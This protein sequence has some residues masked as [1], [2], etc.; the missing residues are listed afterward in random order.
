MKGVGFNEYCVVSPPPA[1]VYSPPKKDLSWMGLSEFV[2]DTVTDYT[3]PTPSLDV[4]KSVSKF[5]AKGDEGSFLGNSLSSKAFR[6][7]NK[8]TKKIEENLHV[9]FL[10]NKSI[11]KGTSP[12]WL[13]DIDTLT[14]SMNYVPVVIEGTSST[15]I[16][17]IKEDVHQAAAKKDAAILDNN[18]SQKEQQEANGDK[19]VPESS[20]NSNPTASTK[21]FANDSFE[22]ASSSTVFPLLVHMFQL[23]A[24][25]FLRLE[26]FFGDTYNA[27]SLNEVESDLSNMETTIQ[28]SL[29]PTLRIH[30]DH[31]KSQIIGPVD[32]PFKIQNVWVLVDYPSGVRPIETKWVLK[33]KKDERGIVIRN[34]A[35]LVAQGHTREEVS[36]YQE[37]FAPVARIEAIRLFLAYASYM[38]FTVYQMDV[39]SAFLYGTINEE[40]YV[41][42][43]LAFKI[44]SSYTEFTRGT[45]DQTLLVRKHKGEF[46]LVQVS[47]IRSLMYLTASRPDIMFAVCACARYQV[48][49]KE[50]H[51]YAVKRIFRYLKGNPKLGLWYPKESPFDLVAYSD[52]DYGG[53]NQ[54]RKSTTGGC[55]FLGRSL[56]RQHSLMEERIQSQDLEITQLKTRVKTLKDNEKRREGFAQEDAPNIR[57]MDQR[58]DLLDR[59][60][61]RGLS[62]GILCVWDSKM[63]VK[64]QI[65][66]HDHFVTVEGVWKIGESIIMGDFNVVRV[67][68]ER[69]GSEFN[70]NMAESFNNFIMENDLVDVSLGG[71]Q[72]TWVNSLAT[73]MSKIDMF[74]ISGGLLERFLDLACTILDKGV[75]D[76]MPI[77][78]K[79]AKTDYGPIRFRFS[80]R[81]W[82]VMGLMSLL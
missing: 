69:M 9:D 3:R 54:D 52:S 67:P 66:S 50:C 61:T 32:T 79:E 8:S 48:T 20:W 34:K 29:T 72:F 26:D 12:D 75:P 13:F 5:D 10:K 31:P 40:V 70:I 82:I 35:H 18:S 63:F 39:K 51:L 17:S 46:F 71:Y 11:E 56:Q 15:N 53:A 30:K 7:F 76:H 2:D 6:V 1:Q 77:L 23:I 81:G 22:L 74:L 24:Y 14:N 73:K 38:G 68:E 62:G 43:P 55:Q 60:K 28:F 42:Q 37:V 49:P 65:V 25:L 4:S 33:N 58:E 57:R 27:V 21:V 44:L 59:N 80:I 78:L 36:D 41:M 64:S 47:M 19:D 45:I 16:S